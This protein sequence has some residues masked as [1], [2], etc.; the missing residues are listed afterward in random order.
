[1]RHRPA[2][3]LRLIRRFARSRR[4]VAAVEF[5]LILPVMLTM[6]LGSQ[7]LSAGIT[8]DQKVTIIAGTIGDL[9][10]R[11]KDNITTA[12]LNDYYKAA[13]DIIAPQSTTGLTEV[14][15][16][17]QVASDGTA[18]TCWSAG[19][20]GGTARTSKQSYPLPAAMGTIAK[21][22]Y[23]IMSEATYSYTPLLGLFFT[24]PFPLYHQNFYM[25]RYNAVITYNSSSG[26]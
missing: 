14:V 9:V 1:M 7:E 15:T 4:G 3:L 26:C 10:A 6:F 17:L 13:D 8:V 25:P 5:A 12:T 11:S 21:G 16:L 2:S 23:V 24:Q 20:N 22:S 18:K 19:Y